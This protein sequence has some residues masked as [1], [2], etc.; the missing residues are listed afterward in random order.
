MLWSALMFCFSYYLEEKIFHGTIYAWI[1]GIP[2]IAF[3][4]YKKDRYNYDLLL[5]NLN[6]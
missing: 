1:V 4:V 2:L 3:A 5:M 6:K